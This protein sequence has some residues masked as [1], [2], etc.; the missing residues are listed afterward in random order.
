MENNNEE[1]SLAREFLRKLFHIILLALPIGYYHFGKQE[2]LKIIT[3]I[4]LVILFFD[5]FRRK[6]EFIKKIFNAIFGVILR[7]KEEGKLSGASFAF[8]AAVIIFSFA[9][10]EIAIASFLILAICD[11]SASLIGKSIKS[12]PF[13]EKSLAGSLSFYIFGVLI[14]LIIGS[15]FSLNILFYIFA[16]FSLSM[17]TIVEARPSL[18]KIDDNF[19]IPI[20]FAFFMTVFDLIWGVI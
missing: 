17:T 5:Y 8:A 14:L 15:H 2:M 6:N 12:R 11:L 4:F 9:K 7:A 20:S 16:L 10:T 19:S 3:P 13:F 18:I 1:F